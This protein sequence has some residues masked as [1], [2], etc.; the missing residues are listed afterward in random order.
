MAKKYFGFS[1]QNHSDAEDQRAA[2]ML[3]IASHTPAS[4]ARKILER[5]DKSL[6][7][8][9][10]ITEKLKKEEGENFMRRPEPFTP[11]D[12]EDDDESEAD[13]PFASLLSPPL[14]GISSEETVTNYVDPGWFKSRWKEWEEAF[15]EAPSESDYEYLRCNECYGC[16]LLPDRLRA[17]IPREY[18]S[19]REM[20]EYVKQFV[21][22]QDNAIDHLAVTFF[23]HYQD[24]VLKN[25]KSV[26]TPVVLL[27]NTGTGKSEILRRF[28][29]LCDCPVVRINST[30]IVPN[31]WRGT[32]LRQYLSSNL[33]ENHSSTDA[34]YAVIVFHEF[35][36]LT[37]K[38]VR[39]VADNS[40][41]FDLDMM[42]EI[43]RLFET[44]HPIHLS[45]GDPFDNDESTLPTDNLLIVFDGAFY[46]LSDI[47]R[48]RM[49]RDERPIGFGRNDAGDKDV[50]WLQ[51]V[52]YDDL[53]EW[54]FYPE[55]LGRIGEL[56]PLKPLTEDLFL[57]IM[58]EAKDSVFDAHRQ[59]CWT[60]NMVL[61]FTEGA[62]RLIARH[63]Q[64][65]GMGFRNVK[66]L[67]ARVM[68]PVYY[69]ID[70]TDSREKHVHIDYAF[71][72]RQ[73]G[74]KTTAAGWE[75]N[76]IVER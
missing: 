8:L 32:S 23:Q 2:A 52:Q 53:L 18:H 20:A 44:G 45:G 9:D 27:G 34:R 41:D 25:K 64:A 61:D 56:V 68:N 29:E 67:L 39:R 72:E 5:Y 65:S 40:S 11:A 70:T 14:P 16:S 62:L 55:L 60:N 22:G 74:G 35:D 36:K 38:N 51:Y 7:T 3:F 31:A 4:E 59:F 1:F 19:P 12:D 13:S 58:R 48:K 73:L 15:G 26:K 57:K 28:C 24:F 47:I 37:H 50:D 49:K 69:K 6:Q 33:S 63:A 10:E 66:T 43:M 21:V 75:N 17:L 54:G 71:V 46:G 42:R 30:D 76:W